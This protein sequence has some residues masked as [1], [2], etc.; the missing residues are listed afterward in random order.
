MIIHKRFAMISLLVFLLLAAACTAESEPAVTETAVATAITEPTS[1]PVEPAL[2]S[3][4]P[5]SDPTVETEPTE[6][7]V[8]TQDV[9]AFATALQFALIGRDFDF[10][11]SQM[12]DPFG[13]GPYRSEWSQLTPAQMVAQLENM[14]PQGAALQFNPDADLLTML[15]GQDPQMMLGPDVT[16]AAVWHTSGWGAEGLDEAILFVEEMGDGRFAWKAMIYAPNGFLPESAEL[17]I[18]DGQPAPVGLLYHKADGSLWQVAADGQPVQLWAQ[19][20]VSPIP[21]PD[22]KHAYYQIQGDL[23]LLDVATGESS[24]L[25]SDH[26]AQG[27]H[28]SG[29]HWWYD[30]STIL[31]G[32]WLDFETDGGPNFGRP[33]L[34]D[35][36][37][38]E[39]TMV[40]SQH[41]MSSYPA[42][43][44]SGAIAYSSVQQSAND[45]ST[46]WIYDPATGVTAFKPTDFT[47]DP[48]GAYTSPA[49]SADG[50]FLAWL[51]SDGI[52]AYPAIFDLESNLVA[53]LP[54]FEGAAFGGPYPNPVFSPD[55]NWIA[56][57]Q[58]T[59]DPATT[60]LWLYTQDGQEPLFIAQNGGE[61]LW[62]NDHL[63]LFIDYDENFNGQLQQYDALTGTRS[64]VTLPD[65]F[66]IFSIIE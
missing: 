55:S 27:T 66:Q 32:I 1:L 23:W 13:F 42:V 3:P 31:S 34:I 39:L 49:W 59:N 10:L 41:L 29:F 15:D 62:L 2:P 44:V 33:A 38:G 50:R 7:A 54:A 18:L 64:A 4:T 19:E 56:L 52:N 11:M 20:G 65:V 17:P 6:T 5:A 25:T 45:H 53:N 40:D 37:T 28:L 26:D 16:V 8:P 30:N 51:A 47:N 9:D 21:A 22:G 24:Q 48:D 63:L 36:A 43:S 14:L 12:S 35:I 57:R 60:G 58:F 61:S 46:S